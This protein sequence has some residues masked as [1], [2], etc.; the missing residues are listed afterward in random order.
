[1]VMGSDWPLYSL[2][3]V[4]GARTAYCVRRDG[5]QVRVEGLSWNESCTLK[6][7]SATATA[8]QFLGGRGYLLAAAN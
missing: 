1:M 7:D 8:R 6:V 5:A 3:A 2:Q 4:H